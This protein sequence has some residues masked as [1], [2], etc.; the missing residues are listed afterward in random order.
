[1][2]FCFINEVCAT[3]N[4]K[5]IANRGGKGELPENTIYAIKTVLEAGVDGVEIDL[6]LTKDNRVVLYNY[7]D[8]AIKTDCQGQVKDLTY[9]EILKCNAAYYF[10]PENDN[11]FP[12]RGDLHKIP[13]LEEVLN[14]VLTGN[15]ILFIDLKSLPSK[16]LIDEIASILDQKNAWNNIVFLSTKNIHL[17]YL[18]DKFPKAKTF[19]PRDQTNKR[20]L[21]LRNEGVCC[22]TNTNNEYVGFETHKSMMVEDVLTLG[23]LYTKVE[24]H[25]W[26]KNAIKCTK[27]SKGENVKIVFLG[28]NNELEYNQ[29]KILGVYAVIT[30]YPI[31]LLNS[32]DS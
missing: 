4:P 22:C 28:V 32:I 3:N 18:N 14:I 11:T 8:L 20:L 19:E 31:K 29:A 7:K 27:K 5:I 24:F 26:D 21:S 17:D 25:L 10:D 6:Q 12:R 2:N 30:D 16:I 15:N 23:P 13:T 1:M 9:N